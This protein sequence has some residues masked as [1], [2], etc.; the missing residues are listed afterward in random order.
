MLILSYFLKVKL[1]KNLN[2]KLLC[3]KVAA[4]YSIVVGQT[5]EKK[6]FFESGISHNDPG[7]IYEVTVL[8][9]KISG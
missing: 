6:D 2:V 7:S 5:Y 4:H 9:R 3:G 8:L 1:K